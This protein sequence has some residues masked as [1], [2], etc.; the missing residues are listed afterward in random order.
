VS[1]NCPFCCFL[2]FIF[3]NYTSEWVIADYRHISNFNLYYCENKIYRH[4]APLRHIIP[5]QSQSVIEFWTRN[6]Q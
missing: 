3:I 6:T 2:R 1:M 4:V 5:I